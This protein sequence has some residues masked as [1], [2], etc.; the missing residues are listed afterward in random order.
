M[1][2]LLLAAGSA[3]RL[4]W[5]EEMREGLSGE[6]EERREGFRLDTACLGIEK[7]RRG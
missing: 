7:K 6:I 2:P 1:V 3:I 4:A 5:W